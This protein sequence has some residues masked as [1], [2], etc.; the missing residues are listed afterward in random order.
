MDRPTLQ[1]QLRTQPLVDLRRLVQATRVLRWTP[2]FV[3][4]GA[5]AGP[6]N[7]LLGNHVT[8]VFWVASTALPGLV[9]DVSRMVNGGRAWQRSE[10]WITRRTVAA[11]V[12]FVAIA[13]SLESVLDRLGGYHPASELMNTDWSQ[14]S[15]VVAVSVALAV[16]RQFL[17]WTR[18]RMDPQPSR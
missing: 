7:L 5:I 10:G 1:L 14:L 15:D 9:L 3:L 4:F 18:P 8:V 16:A 11:V 13:L 2:W 12:I 6:A 17:Q